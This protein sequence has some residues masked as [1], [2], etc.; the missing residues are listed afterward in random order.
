MSNMSYCRFNN[1][2]KDLEDC[3]EHMRD[4][5]SSAVR[6]DDYDSEHS[7]RTRLIE[8]CIRI[9]SEYGAVNGD[10]VLTGEM[11]PIEDWEEDEEDEE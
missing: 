10:G 4:N 6:A 2:L 8:L 3:N 9:A 1:T 5:L 7:K 11:Q